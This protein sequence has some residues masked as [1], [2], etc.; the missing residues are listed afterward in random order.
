[1]LTAAGGATA[2]P[3]EIVSISGSDSIEKFSMLRLVA[4]THHHSNDQRLVPI[5]SKKQVM[6]NSN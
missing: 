3:G 1:M 2:L 4:I 6:V 5:D